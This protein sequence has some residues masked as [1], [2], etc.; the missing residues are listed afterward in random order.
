MDFAFLNAGSFISTAGISSDHFNVC[1]WDLLVPPH[2]ALVSAIPCHEDGG[3]HSVIYS[4][5]HQL[6]FSGGK[7]GE[8]CTWCG[9]RTCRQ[10]ES[11]TD[12]RDLCVNVCSHHRCTTTTNHEYHLGTPRNGQIHELASSGTPACHWFERW[13]RQD[14]GSAIAE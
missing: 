7:Q 11:G 12:D 14:L 10:P 6:L 9:T 5:R 1:F 4:P 13:Q 8:I 2:K 3:A